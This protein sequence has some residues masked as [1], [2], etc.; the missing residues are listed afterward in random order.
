MWK[1]TQEELDKWGRE[2]WE[3][4]KYDLSAMRDGCLTLE[5]VQARAKRRRRAVGLTMAQAARALPGPG[6]RS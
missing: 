1:G 5:D 4:R 3:H 6:K 2:E